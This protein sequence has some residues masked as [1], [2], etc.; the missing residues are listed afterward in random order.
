MT[1]IAIVR[2][3]RCGNLFDRMVEEIL[4]YI[5]VKYGYNISKWKALQKMH[6]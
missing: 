1:H 5:H 2:R 3:M 6:I 4:L